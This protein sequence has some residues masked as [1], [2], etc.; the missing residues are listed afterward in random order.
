M[1]RLFGFDVKVRPGFL[2][3]M[4]LIVFVNQNAFG[5][6]L[7]GSLAGFTLLHEL[8]HAIA[9]RRAGAQAAISLDFMAGYTSFRPRTPLK[10]HQQ[11]L[12]SAAGPLTQI[13]I[14]VAAL[15][16]LGVNPLS[17]DSALQSEAAY[18]IWWA[19]PVIGVLNLV[20]VLPLDGGHLTQTV[21][22]GVLKRPALREMAI[23][24]LAVTAAA[25][26]AMAALGHSQFT[27]F[28][29]FLLIGQI[30][31]VQAT[32]KAGRRPALPSGWAL[33]GVHLQP[34]V[35]PSPWQQAYAAV[36]RGE[37]SLAARCILDDLTSL[38]GPGVARWKPPVDAP[39]EAL[40][41]VVATLPERLPAGNAYSESVLA[42]VLLATG[43]V[44]QAGEYA[45]EGFGR[46][47]APSM[48][49]TVA[50]AAAQLGDADNAL[51]W[52]DA[53]VNAAASSSPADRAGL[54]HVLD[55]AHELV[56]LRHRSEFV[57]ARAALV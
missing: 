38:P 39:L 12:I 47:R 13:A 5:L 55:H 27:L 11:A 34:G 48:A 29:A 41:A 16:A 22:E 28:I 10:G 19:G 46:H 21:L 51:L 31:L 56:E 50:R 1:F 18:A 49:A 57:R 24:S 37:G 7:A 30:Q 3:F 2:L 53:A 43:S 32:S 6:W 42:D 35:R 40:Q 52:V 20:P 33:D 8:G 45:A 54:A 23:A 44:K 14:S 26:I 4:G 9:A 15:A 17:R 25:A 36:A